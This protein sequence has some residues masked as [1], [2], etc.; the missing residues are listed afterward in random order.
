MNTHLNSRTTVIVRRRATT[1]SACLI[2]VLLTAATSSAQIFDL[3]WYTIDGG[4][5]MFTAGGSFELSGTIGQPDA[6]TMSGGNFEL[7]GGF[8]AI[9][10]GDSPPCDPCDMNCDG[11]INAL[12]IEPFL[13]LLFGGGDPC[14]ACSGDV[15]GDGGINALDIEPFLECLFP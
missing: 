4:G 10:G 5:E 6:G 14:A 13:D 7:T 11:D 9:R 15:N 1:R 3:S 12:D 8:W 2:A